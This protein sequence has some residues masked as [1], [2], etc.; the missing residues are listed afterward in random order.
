MQ[1][2]SGKRRVGRPANSGKYGVKTQVMRVPT[3]RVAEISNFLQ[4]DSYKFALYGNKVAAG[5]PAMNE[6]FIE[7]LVDLNHFLVKKPSSTFLVRVS[8]DSMIDVGIYPGDILVVD[9]SLEIKH[10]QI[11]VAIIDG[12]LTV[13]RLY[14]KEGLL[15]LMPENKAYA[16]IEVNDTLVIWG[17]VRH[18]IHSYGE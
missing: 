15:K 17:V 7:E 3:D 8:G 6:E 10:G 16:P 5:T 4:R 13:K 18:V 14:Q 2:D 1:T 12:G 9:H 11:I